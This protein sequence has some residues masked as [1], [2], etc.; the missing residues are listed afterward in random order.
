MDKTISAIHLNQKA[1]IYLAQG[2]LEAAITAC[3]QALE[4]EQNFPLTCK[5]LGNILQRM[6]EIDKAKEWYI[7]AINQQ[8]NLAEAHANLGSIYAQQKQWHLA[9]ECYREAIG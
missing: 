9:I 2:K 7:K 5:I 8:P 6:G 3:Y 1:E 4:I